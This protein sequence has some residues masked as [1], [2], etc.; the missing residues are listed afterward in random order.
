MPKT[1]TVKEV[2]DILGFSTNSIYSFLKEKR[3]RGVRIGKGR[4]RIPEEELSRVLHLSK[5]A[6]TTPETSVVDKD[7]Q[8]LSVIPVVSDAM[9]QTGDATFIQPKDETKENHGLLTPNIFDWFIG[10]GAIVAGVALFLFNS[11]FTIEE[12]PRMTI[13]Y[14]IIRLV[15]IACGLGILISGLF[16]Q[17]KRWHMVFHVLL[18]VMGFFNAFGLIKSGDIEGG[19]LYG[20]L[21]FVIALTNFVSFGGIVSV[22]LYISL[23]AFLVPA[24]ILFFPTDSHVQSL[25]VFLGMQTF[26]IG[27]ISLIVS[28]ALM[29]MFWIGYAK[30]RKLF[31]LAAWL[32]TLGDIGIA[33]WYAHLQYWSRAFFILVLAAFTALLPYWWPLQQGISRKY[34]LMLHGLFVGIGAVFV[35]AVLIVYLLQQSIWEAREREVMNKVHIG[36]TRLN[37]AVTSIQSSL[38]VAATN[39]DFVESLNKPDV[40][41]LNKY[42]KIIYESNP[43]IRRL[44]F[45][46]KDGE[47]VALYPYGTFDEPN[48]AYRDYYQEPKNTGKPYISDVFQARADQ[49]GRYVVSITVPLYEDGEFGGV[50]SASMDLDRIGLLLNQIASGGQGEY[51]VVADAKGVIVS[52]PDEKLIGT[53]APS[54]DPLYRALKGEEGLTKGMMIEKMLGMMGYT[55]VP[56]LRWGISLRLPAANV[57]GLSAEDIVIVFGVVVTLM[58]VGITLISY[59]RG[60]VLTDKESGP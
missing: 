50:V 20:A 9:S 54:S 49:S 37:N 58:G 30:D 34:K 57:F 7:T 43:N 21:A 38:I 12:F 59:I 56:E 8:P 11:T 41:T 44:I 42:S 28:I 51:F 18:S 36:H 53:L 10:L 15:L 47:G 3:I 55:Y 23:I 2:A 25:S 13:A 52:H 27:V 31:L 26:V 45:L 4:F 32:C 16:A 6:T 39:A 24:V 14:P 22:G 17:A 46:N 40:A 48:F 33:L 19:A 5:K 1:Y 29:I 60:R 35:L